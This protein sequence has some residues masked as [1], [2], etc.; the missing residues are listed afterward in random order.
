MYDN[1][2][3]PLPNADV[4]TNDP[5]N[6]DTYTGYTTAR[7][8]GTVLTLRAGTGDNINPS[9]YFSWKMP[10]DIGGNFYRDNIANCNQTLMVA[11]TTIIQEPGDKSGPTIQGINDLIDKDPNAIWDKTCK[12][13]KNSAFAISPRV[14]PIPLYDPAYYA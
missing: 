1:K 11:G 2:G 14:F 3:N 8:A 9:F 5:Y 7:D 4:Y 13:V 6:P 10:G 12:C